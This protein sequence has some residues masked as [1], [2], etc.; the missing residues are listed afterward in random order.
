VVD[1]G[2]DG[3]VANVAQV[4]ISCVVVFW[5]WGRTISGRDQGTGVP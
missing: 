4:E 1:V 5:R 2:D 3:D